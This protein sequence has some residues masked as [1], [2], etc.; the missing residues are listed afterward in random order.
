MMV[1]FDAGFLSLTFALA[2]LVN[3]PKL[4]C[5]I[6]F[7]AV[8]QPARHIGYGLGFD[9]PVNVGGRRESKPARHGFQLL[10]LLAADDAVVVELVAD[11]VKAA[12]QDGK[13]KA[14]GCDDASSRAT[15]AICDS[16]TKLLRVAKLV[17]IE[18]G[19]VSELSKLESSGA[20]RPE[21]RPRHDECYPE[22]PCRAA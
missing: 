19:V 2:A 6:W 20:E 18:V 14:V 15:I 7:H 5:P 10:D 3:V 4:L 17:G 16:V 13:E 12:M 22:E 1:M 8:A 21:G 11:A 9:G